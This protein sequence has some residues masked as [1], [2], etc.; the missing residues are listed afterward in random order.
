MLRYAGR[1]RIAVTAFALAFGFATPGAAAEPSTDVARGLTAAEN[2]AFGDATL[3]AFAA[4]AIEV[5]GLRAEY[6]PRI[7]VAASA[8]SRERAEALF[9]EMRARMHEAIRAGGLDPATYDA[10][11][12]AA[13]ADPTLRS[14]I[15][16]FMEGGAAREASVPERGEQPVAASPAAPADDGSARRVARELDAARAMLVDLRG[17]LEAERARTQIARTELAETR[18][19]HA[20]RL[21]DVTQER[22]RDLA[23]LQRAEGDRIALSREIGWHARRLQSVETA[24]AALAADMAS[25]PDAEPDE[26]SATRPA[27]FRPLEPVAAMRFE[28]ARRVAVLP[29]APSD[30]GLRDELMA[31]RARAAGDAARHGAERQAAAREMTRLAGDLAS[32]VAAL[33]G[34]AVSVALAPVVPAG[35][36]VSGDTT[37]ADVPLAGADDAGPARPVAADPVAADP[38][39]GERDA[40]TPA[41]SVDRGPAAAPAGA[42]ADSPG[43]VNGDGIMDGIA[44]Y[45]DGDYARAFAIWTPLAE[46]GV[47]RAQFHLAALHFEGRGTPRDL[48]AAGRWLARALE[49]GHAAAAG[50]LDRI[51]R[52]T[53]K[54][55]RRELAQRDAVP[56]PNPLR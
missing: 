50:L 23:A 17:Q 16:R 48:D 27:A 56:V 15:D 38:V 14:R 21:L 6:T 11:A 43:T 10:I 19:R 40:E 52:E 45:V 29:P 1:N 24:M 18:A 34:L 55:G 53:A 12:A 44:A 36:P 5:E 25:A 28:S 20:A 41:S 33:E 54:S 39:E 4:A 47:A 37:A 30:D 22:A 32:G 42:S 35:T 51:A 46:R 49:G 7:R 2:A 13:Q 3:R 26:P 31:L 9:A 8:Q